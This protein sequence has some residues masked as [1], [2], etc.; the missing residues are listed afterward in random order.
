MDKHGDTWWQSVNGQE[1]VSIRL[2]LEA[3]FHFTHLIMKFKTFRPAAMIIERSADFGRTWRP[4]RYFASNC[5]KTFPGIS[6]NGLHHINDIICEER[7]S[8]I[9]PSTKGEVIYKVLDPAIHV[10]DP[11]S[12]DIQ[13][14]LRITNLR[15][16]FTKL[17]TLGDDLLDRRFDVLQK[18]YYA[19]Y[20]LVVR[21]SCFCYGHASECAPVPGVDVR[22]NGMIHGRCV[23]KHNTEGL[24]C[25]RCQRFHHDL[26]WRPA[27]VENPHTC[28]ECNCNGHSSQCHFDMAV[29]LATGNLSGGVCDDCQHNT[30]GRNCESCKPFYYKD[31]VKDTRDPRVCVACDCDPVG[32]LEGGVCDSHTDLDMGMIAGQCRCKAHV[33]GERCDDCKEGYYGLSQNDPLGCQ[34]CNCNPR[35]IIMMGAPCDQISGDCSCKRYV[36][37]RY[38]NQCLPEY[39]GLSNDLAG[40]RQCDCDFGGAVN[41]RCMME[42]GQ[43]DCRR[44]LIG[45][46]CSE[47]QP[48]YFCAPLDYYKYEAEDATGHSPG[49]PALPSAFLLCSVQLFHL[50]SH[51]PPPPVVSSPLVSSL[52]PSSPP[53]VVSSPLVS[54][55]LPSSTSSCGLLSSCLISS[56]ILPSSCG[57]L[58]SCFISS[59]ILPSSRGLLSSCFISSPILPS[60]CGL[61]SSCFISSPILPSSRGLLSSCFISSPIL[62]SS[63]GLLS[64]SFISSPILPSSR[65][66]LS[67]CYI[68]SPILPSS[69]G[70]L[71]S[72]FIS[73]PILP[74][75]CGLLSSCFISSPI[76]PSSRGLLSSC[77]I[78]SPI[79]PSS[80]GLLSSCFIS[81]PILHLLLWSP[82]L[83]FHLFSHP[84]LLLWSPL[85]LLHL[86]SHPPLLLWSPLLLFH[87]FSHP[88]PPPVVSSPLVTSLLP[89]SPPPVVSSPLV[90]S[91]LPSSPSPVVSSPL[92]S[93]LLPSSPPPVVSSPLVSSL[94]P[95]SPSPVVSSP[96]AS[97]LIYHPPLFPSSRSHLLLSR[98]LPS[99]QGKVRPQAETDCVQHLSNQLRRH[100]RHHRISNSQQHRAALRRIRQ[101]Q[102]TPDVRTVHREHTA[103]HMVTWTGPGFARVKDGAGLVLT[104]DN[105]PYAMEYDIMI[106]YEP[107]STEDWEA[108][109]SITSVQLPTSLRCGNLLPT[110]QL[111]TVTLPHRNRYIQMPRPFCF[112]PSNSYV[113]AIRFQ[114][115]GVSHRH[116]TAFILIDSLVLIPKYTELPGLQ[117]PEPEAEQRREEMIRYMCLDSFMIT[118]MPVLAE[119]CSKLICS[120]SSIIHNGALPCQCDPQGSLSGECDKVGGQCRCKANVM[121]R[122]CD[123]CAPGTYGFGV[124]GCTACD[125]HS[126]GSSSRQC[127]PA[128]GQCQC[129]PGATGRQCSDCQPGQWGFPSCGPCQCN[130]HADICDSRTGECR[131]CR[132]YTAGHLC[133]RCVD[134]FFG[135]PVLG[136]G[137]HC[138]PCPCPGNPGSDHFNADS[139]QAD[140]TSNQIICN[141][142]Q[143]YTGLR[144]DQCAPGHYGNPDQPGGQ[145]FPCNCNGNIDTQDPESCDRTTG[146]CLKCQ[147]HT[148]G[149]SCDHC[150]H[151][152][153]GNALGH[154][155]RRCTCVTAGTVQSA[156]SDGQCHCDRQTGACTCRENVAGHNCDECAP[157][158]WNYG[159]DRGCEPCGCD[160]QHALGSH[161]N[162]FTGHCHCQPG[163]GGR[164]C[165]ECE[166]F[167]WGDPQVQCQ[168]CNCHPLG[169]EMAQ[170]DRLTGTC[171]CKEGAAGKRCDECA[172]GFTGDFPSCVQCHPCFQLWDDAVCQIKRDM[173]HIQ[174]TVQKIL[175]SGVM[176]EIGDTRIRELEMKL[177]EVQDLISSQDSERIHQL[178]GQSIDDLRAEI[179]LT[180]GRLMGVA[181][182]INSTAEEESELRHTLSDLERELRDINATVAQKQRLL[183]DYLTSGFADQFEKVKKYYQESLSAED[184][185]NASVSG[186]LSPVEQ[187]KTSRSV[188][189]DL[190][191]ATRDNFL[192]SLAAQNK[193]LSELQQKG[194]DLDKN[195]HQLSHK[196]C[197][198]H[199][200]A[201]VNGSCPHSR[202]GGAGCRD[203]QGNHVCGGDGCNGTVSTSVRA[204]T[205]AR[206]ATDRVNA[207]NEELQ[208]VARKLQD[209]ATL[210]QDVKN[211]AMNTLDK[212]QKKKDQFENNNEKLKDFI[213]KIRDFLT[214]EGADPESIEKVALQVL[215]IT[216]PAN[217]TTLDKMVMKIKDSLSNLTDVEGIVNQTAQHI[218]KAK[219]L[220]A[221][222]EEAKS[223]AEGVKDTANST[224]QAL[225]ESEKAI[226]EATDALTEALNNLN[227]TRNAAAQVD[228]RLTQLE[229]KQ[230]DVMMRLNTLT[231]EVE[232]LRNKTEQNRQKAK[233]AE[234]LASNATRV[235]SSLEQSLNDTEERY[236]EL[237][238]KV[239]SLGGES[240]GLNSINSKV[241]EIKK[242]A[243]D[244]LSKASQG[245]E[246]LR[247]LEKK[248]KSNEERMKKQRM[249]LDQLKDK[250]TVVRDE[251]RA[252]VQKYSNCD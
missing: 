200:N 152:Y 34:P 45:R 229:D 101:L 155:C 150:Q 13:E 199:S 211:Q 106:R 95:S 120:I 82:L 162:M 145:C 204:V 231:A 131:D 88:P 177:L 252:Q 119:M 35:G 224:K 208:G 157:N 61:L 123:Q 190:L 220:L 185:C 171:E 65:G 146:Q 218:S 175:E 32:S 71:S 136:S 18:Y 188:T 49:D 70:L 191:N 27:E 9:E 81:S 29:Y 90:S 19:I 242:E 235:A 117:G 102:Q 241:I 110:E 176:P 72:C 196:V 233:E 194:L 78:S 202:C 239:D 230:K 2:N 7:Y 207:A 121:G 166:Q 225:D 124:K 83:L 69:R 40:C 99:S 156:C 245:I 122:R 172:R 187:S 36:T 1:N 186:P 104:I 154:D 107:E 56:P 138:R 116:L 206:N 227:S 234:A 215:A 210:T 26:P 140:H 112:E 111:Y 46:Q 47:V 80:C 249:E 85:L 180:D 100:R 161:C 137:G 205:L 89:S 238:M 226:K 20:E 98:C 158:H 108:I 113:V 25:E 163:F 55:L 77:Y 251:I 198:G 22:E 189:D 216:L 54:S 212:A 192:R 24:N 86:F 97:S 21:G 222:A 133:E 164:Q 103:S 52:L 246:Q 5:T 173:E 58:S 141:C 44:H 149:A 16:N 228:E 92:A 129:R 67:S 57:L 59:P 182:E 79:L 250:A 144:C 37:G 96:L 94:L 236:R 134:G 105:I 237:Q 43:C 143:G 12:L 23:C 76:L 17:N 170:C 3:E 8:D 51:P 6:A 167:H 132:D 130:G 68:S 10:K 174:Y 165:S 219:E 125:C 248:F 127:D 217:K 221:E 147:Y 38:C 11:Y 114:R 126:E 151:G 41:N 42:N 181:Q 214:E 135:N 50:F 168:E 232:A 74:S 153:Y 62:P 179:A 30:M 75:S 63:C 159:Q 28:R 64:S 184:K 14:L 31:P 183:D 128:S 15:I 247:K 48:G 160:L 53:P 240:G 223:R 243:E 60:S 39:W 195:V 4:Y 244:L 142:R 178:I 84:P 193:S 148:D 169:S 209:I 203:D 197:G 91:L 93:S 87:L 66:L 118:P 201:S 109:V 33:R 115:H 73:S 213:K 139:C